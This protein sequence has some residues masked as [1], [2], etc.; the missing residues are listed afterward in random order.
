MRREPP[1]VLFTT[2]EMLNRQLSDGTNGHVF[3][4]GPRA[5]RKPEVMLLDEVH[6]YE[7]TTGAQAAYVI[8]RWRHAIGRPVQFVGLSAT[9]RD[10][11]TFFAQLVGLADHAVSS[12]APG[13]GELISEGMEYMLALR[14]DPVSGTSLLATTIQASMLLRRTLDH[15]RSSVRRNSMEAWIVVASRLVPD[16][17]SPRSA[18]MYSMPSLMSSPLPGAMLDTAWSARP[19]SCAKNVCASRSVAESPT[20]W[21][22]RPIA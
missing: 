4:V 10:A 22:G 18:S 20:N 16:T 21:T 1:D 5:A 2:T 3:G 14:G 17:G 9:L 15:D 13:S 6:T 12:I 8:R 11:Q 7:G 19:T